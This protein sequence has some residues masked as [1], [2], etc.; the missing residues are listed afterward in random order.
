[1]LRKTRKTSVIDKDGFR[2]NVG[3]VLANHQGLVF[4]GK[5]VGPHDSWQFP[6]GGLLPRESL[7]EALFRELHEEVGLTRD[8]V[9]IVTQVKHW[10]Y[11]RL[12]K[13]YIRHHSYPL[14]IGQ[15]QKWF[16]LRLI[17]EDT[18]IHLDKHPSP[19][20]DS[21][22]WVDCWAP[23]KSVV[24]FKRHVYREVLRE[25]EPTLKQWKHVSE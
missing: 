12:P 13:Q 19:E 14:C 20:F 6:Q 1:M 9:E 25:F 11:Y 23:M 4:L 3:I 7:E 16:L 18:C 2:A 21:W 24:E 17:A 10:I 8:D 22:Q 15:K 5:R